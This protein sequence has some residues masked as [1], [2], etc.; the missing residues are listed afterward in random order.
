ML[1]HLDDTIA[2]VA[3][4]PGAGVRGIV[5]ISGP[6]LLTLL[7]RLVADFQAPMSPTSLP[8]AI[9]LEHDSAAPVWLPCDLYVWPTSRSYTGEPLAEFHTLGSPPLLDLLLRTVLRAGNPTDTATNQADEKTR[10]AQPGEFTL[11]AFLAGRLDLTQAE[12]VLGV[13]DALDLRHLQVALDQLAGGLSSRIMPLRA[14]LLNLLADLEAGL[15]FADEALEF[16]SHT[17]LVARL[18]QARDVVQDL[19]QHAGARS[20]PGRTPRVV[21]VGPPNAG[22]STLFNALANRDLALVSPERGTTRDYLAAEVTW[23]GCTFTLVDTAGS[24]TSANLIESQAQDQRQAQVTAADLVIA[25]RAPVASMDDASVDEPVTVL[26]MSDLVPEGDPPS[27]SRALRVSAFTGAG[28]DDLRNHIIQRLT[29]ESARQGD[30]IAST[31]VRGRDSLIQAA[32]ALNRALDIATA[33]T[34]QAVL[35]IEIRESLDELG[36]I[37]G[38]V[39]TDDILDRVFSRFCIGK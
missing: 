26:T 9:R 20:V 34:D 2:A 15:D 36:S 32:A 23:Q 31:A 33:E 8:C 7:P 5:R 13:I 39:Y 17:Q 38:A 10:L 24:E 1:P 6:K 37:V 14:D 18:Q 12:A 27:L 21:L 22:K 16:V 30:W 28:L 11:R 4:A 29:G 19:L 35:A 25:C 3:S